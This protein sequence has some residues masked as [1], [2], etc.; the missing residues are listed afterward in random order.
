MPCSSCGSVETV[1][2][3]NGKHLGEY[4]AGCDKWIR[5]VPQDWKNFIWP[6]GN[7]H[8]G[9]TL[10]SILV[11]DRPYLEWASQNMSGSLQKRAQEALNSSGVPEPVRKDSEEMDAFDR[12]SR[13]SKSSDDWDDVPW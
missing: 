8:K 7:K 4:C 10:I 9:H 6:V 11:N 3:S 5:W 12:L 2:K 1:Q 13:H